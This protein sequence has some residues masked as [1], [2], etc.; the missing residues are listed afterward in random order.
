M[1]NNIVTIEKMTYGIDSLAHLDGKVVFIPYGVPGDKVR[2][3]GTEDKP[4]YVR[5]KI[6]EIIE[7]SK[8]R[9]KSPCPNFP[10][11]GGCHWQEMHPE[12]QRNEKENVLNFIIKALSFNEKFKSF[13]HYIFFLTLFMNTFPDAAWNDLGLAW[14]AA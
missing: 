8:Y 4:D 9:R 13:Y 6:V 2:I 5:A 1:E 11:C 14:P 12:T 3:E 7:P 10:K